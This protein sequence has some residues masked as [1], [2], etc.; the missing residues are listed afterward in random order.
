MS[1]P[2]FGC[3]TWMQLGHHAGEERIWS[4]GDVVPWIDHLFGIGHN[5]NAALMPELLMATPLGDLPE[6]MLD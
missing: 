1:S 5:D 4:D 6:A 2:A 3:F